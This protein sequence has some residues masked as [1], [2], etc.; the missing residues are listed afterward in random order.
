VQEAKAKAEKGSDEEERM[1][2]HALSLHVDSGD[3]HELKHI[4]ANIGSRMGN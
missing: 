3:T 4:P 2:L 1:Y